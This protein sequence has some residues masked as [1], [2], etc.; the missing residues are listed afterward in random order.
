MVQWFL[1]AILAAHLS[2]ASTNGTTSQSDPDLFITS[3]RCLACHNSLVNDS[4]QNV[5]I[6]SNWQASMM[7]HASCDP[8]WQA[9]VRREC[10]EHPTAQAEIQHECAGCHMPM[11]RYHAKMKGVLGSVFNH[12][13][14]V[15]AHTPAD[16]LAADA[17]SCTLCHQITPEHLGDAESFTAGFVIDQQKPE[18][19]RSI[20]GPYDVDKGRTRV[21]QSSSLFVPTEKTHLQ[22]SA[23]CASCHTLYTHTLN[24]QGVAIGT[25]PEQVPYLEWQHSD[26][27]DVQHCQSCHMPVLETPMPITS[28][29]GQD[30]DHFSQHAFRGGNFFIPKVL[31]R[32]RAELGVQAL[33][34]DL[35]QTSRATEDHL[36]AQSAK[37][38]IQSSQRNGDTLAVQVHVT[39]LAG[40]KLPTAY[41][42]RRTWIHLR[43]TDQ[44]GQVVFES[45]A[46][47]KD[48]SIAGNDN[49]REAS[50]FEPHYR[51][52]TQEDQVQ[53]YEAIMVDPKDRVTTSLLTAIRYAK[54]NRI[55]PK[56]FDK[57]TAPADIAVHGQAEQDD[58]FLAPR[59]SLSY[60]IP[61]PTGQGPFHVQ[62]ELWYQPIAY[63]WAHNLKQQN[64]VEIDRFTRYYE[65]M[66]QESAII[67]A[68]DEGSVQ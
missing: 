10:L 49:D 47:R 21:M 14:V 29:L 38:T 51:E 64:A 15:P 26:Y 27:N 18:G 30:R 19:E 55:L 5:S 53:I 13:P 7:A 33:A 12:L 4:G 37:L 39:N 62:A 1:L 43:V 50:R 42:S 35:N 22:D 3:D 45:G 20:Y 34:Q 2:A 40:H 23:L 8:Y 31:N 44:E 24:E 28:V 25:F 67:L 54:D 9:A 32:Y 56:G 46:L 17:V 16:Q 61:V 57:T 11:N 52:I 68:M 60:Q 48:G 66:S 36:A 58:D 59:D 63:R 41:P 65:A 6:G